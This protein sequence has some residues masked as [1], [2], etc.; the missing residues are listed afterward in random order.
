MQNN[1]TT[2]LSSLSGL[3]SLNK[4]AQEAGIQQGTLSKA[5]L[6]V[7]NLP[8]KHVFHIVKALCKRFG[9][10]TIAGWRFTSSEEDPTIFGVKD[11]GPPKTKKEGQGFVYLQPQARS[12]FDQIEIA[13]LL[14][15]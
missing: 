15:R 2:Y 8:D 11:E 4:L 9:S 13:K 5:V 6:G 10:V 12:T 3:I 14:N 7:R 1:L